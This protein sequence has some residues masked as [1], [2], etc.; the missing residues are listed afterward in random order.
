MS[1]TSS[2][3]SPIER[4]RV[5]LT[6]ERMMY[7]SY[8]SCQCGGRVSERACVRE[9]G[10]SRIVSAELAKAERKA[11]AEPKTHPHAS[12]WSSK[13]QSAPQATRS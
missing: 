1:L 5:P 8:S 9:K 6:K 4:T 7:E 11:R 12:T 13:P 3:V 10:I 2:I